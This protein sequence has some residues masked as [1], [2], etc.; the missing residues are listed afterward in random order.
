M[1]ASRSERLYGY[2][3]LDVKPSSART[4]RIRV[5]PSPRS[6]G[7]CRRADEIEHALRPLA[8][9]E[10]SSWTTA[11]ALELGENSNG[12]QGH[13]A[14]G[15]ERRPVPRSRRRRQGRQVSSTSSRRRDHR[16]RQGRRG[17]GGAIL[18][19]AVLNAYH[20]D[21]GTAGSSYVVCP[22][23]GDIVA[24][25]GGEHRRQRR[26][27]ERAHRQDRRRTGHAP[28]L[29]GRGHAA[30]GTRSGV[31]PTA[32]NAVA[33][34]PGDRGRLRRRQLRRHAGDVLHLVSRRARSSAPW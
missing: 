18:G 29:G 11:A 3:T 17:G 10:R 25:R 5:E 8:A 34:R 22:F 9:S 16:R 28:G 26:H 1:R 7:R 14:A 2:D 23:D 15:I 21:I 6:P 31:V 24:A 32:A 19:R 20:A 27:E 30:A 13:E 4:G 12:R 33:R